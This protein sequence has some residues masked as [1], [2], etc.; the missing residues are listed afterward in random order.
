MSVRHKGIALAVLALSQLMIV[1]DASIVNVAL[2]SIQRELGFSAADLQWVVNAYTLAF[3]GFLLLGGRLADRFGRRRLFILGLALFCIASALGGFA[4]TSMLLIIA[5]AIQGFGG[6]LMAPAALSLLTV[7]FSEGEE[8]NKALGVW[9]AIAAGGAAIGLLLGGLLVQYLDW[10]WVLFVN[11]PFALLGIVGALRFVPESNDEHVKGFD[12]AGAVTVTGGLVAL[13]YALVRGNEVGWL[14]AQTIV[15]SAVALTLLATFF[16]LQLRGRTPLMPL[17]IFEQ[18]HVVGSDLALLLVGAGMFGMFFYVSIYLQ[19]TLHYSAIKTG[20]A[21]LPVS[22]VI[23]FSAGLGSQLMNKMTPRRIA[24]PSLA[25]AGIG[26]LLLVRVGPESSYLGS[27]LPAMAI[28]AFGMGGTF[29]SLT[30]SAVAGVPER[31]SGLASA[32]LNTAQ[33]I[34][35]SLG[36]ALLTAVSTGREKTVAIGAP[37]AADVTSGYAWAFGVAGGMLLTAAAIVAFTVKISQEE[38]AVAAK[39][40]MAAG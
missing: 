8:R 12:V 24:A 13:V 6:A 34:G 30:A 19:G 37:V 3:G 38:A 28:M 4:Q 25:V 21:F 29:V 26:M 1:L 16:R 31:D 40:A 10:R 20:L 27:I 33:Q 14:S 36:L 39:T 17:R 9:G 11:I 23:M 15:T 18:R 32:L 7:I 5:R 35:G 2:S 22:L